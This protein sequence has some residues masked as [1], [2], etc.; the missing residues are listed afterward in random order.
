MSNPV[1]DSQLNAPNPAPD[2]VTIFDLETAIEGACKKVLAGYDIPGFCQFEI[3]DLPPERVDI[4]LTVGSETGHRG[5]VSPGIFTPDAWNCVL[6]FTPFTKRLRG[7]DGLAREFRGRIRAMMQYFMGHFGPD[8]LPYHV[9]TSIV[10]RG[11]DPQVNVDDDLDLCAITYD[12]KV[13]VRH[14]AWPAA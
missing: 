12:L 7:K 2:Y 1:P 6:K 8:V 13:S 5:E 4:Q 11:A 3:E 14:G 10:H 9:L